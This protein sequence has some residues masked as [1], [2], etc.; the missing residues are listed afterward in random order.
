MEGIMIKI[1]FKIVGVFVFPLLLISVFTI[2]VL[3]G[4]PPIIDIPGNFPGETIGTSSGGW[5]A[6]FI[7]SYS[8]N[9][10]RENRISVIWYSENGRVLKK[11]EGKRI[12]ANGYYILERKADTTF[13]H[14]IY[15]TTFI[16][17]LPGKN[18]GYSC[19]YGQDYGKYFYREYSTDSGKY[20]DFYARGSFIGSF[21]PNCWITGRAF[22]VS[23]SGTFVYS[24]AD[25]NMSEFCTIVSCDSLGNEIFRFTADGPLIGLT[26]SLTG[27]WAI[28][29]YN[30][31]TTNRRGSK[32]YACFTSTGDTIRIHLNGGL[33]GWVPG[34]GKMIVT[35]LID[36][37]FGYGL[38]NWETGEFEWAVKDPLEYTPN[39]TNDGWAI[40]RK[41][42]IL[43]GLAIRKS[44][45]HGPVI[46]NNLVCTTRMLAAIDIDKGELVA[47]WYEPVFS[48]QWQVGTAFP[49]MPD[50][51]GRL[52]WLNDNL[53]HIT[54]ENFSM[55]DFGDIEGLS[56]GWV[57]PTDSGKVY[58]NIVH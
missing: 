1:F 35:T 55:I 52:I 44:V 47:E 25:S 2:N 30:L 13:V 45:A 41:Y 38:L 40:S 54:S 16:I 4:R 14:T 15:D 39:A 34:T 32:D 17:I 53:Y 46:P 49:A 5:I 58:Y 26:P 42:F 6:P 9:I 48:G 27:D 11:I 12:D 56:N 23:K 43:S 20:F 33:M 36:K 18:I 3:S 24:L 51:G 21:G 22:A 8:T 7:Y 31:D 50:R 19:I 28:I 37:D 57:A 10:D 29:Q